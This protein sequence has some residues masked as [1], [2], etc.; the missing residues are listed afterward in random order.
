MGFY[1]D[2]SDCGKG[3]FIGFVV[4][5]LIMAITLIALSHPSIKEGNNAIRV[6]EVSN[7][8]YRDVYP[9]GIHTVLPDS[10]F[11]SYPFSFENMQISMSCL[12][13][14]GIEIEID[15][16]LQYSFEPTE[17]AE[18]YLDLG[19]V[20][21]NINYLR[22]HAHSAIYKTC[23]Y[24]DAVE[25]TTIRPV[26]SLN[27]SF[28]VRDIMTKERGNTHTTLGL[29]QLT[30]F[31]YPD[32][33]QEAV[34]QKQSVEQQIP[35]EER[36]RE[37]ILTEETTKQLQA[38]QAVNILINDANAEAEKLIRQ[39]DEVAQTEIVTWQQII[40]DLDAEKTQL[41]LSFTDFIIYKEAVLIGDAK[42]A[43]VNVNTM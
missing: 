11:Y 36:R 31:E 16:N 42:N 35:I 1:S 32:L 21:K 34:N 7:T 30:N 23:S 26:V 9:P 28:A 8:I 39:A 17:L 18:S 12:S 14:N 22:D 43:V 29:F 13:K 10:K 40:L 19:S 20:D 2:M 38:T 41:G 15:T 27:M 3:T 6:D 25:F 33:F 5:L 4:A 37:Q 24:F